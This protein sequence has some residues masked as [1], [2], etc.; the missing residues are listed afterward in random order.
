VE[1]FTAVMSE[2]AVFAPAKRRFQT[3]DG[4]QA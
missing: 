4:E 1:I 3:F 2:N